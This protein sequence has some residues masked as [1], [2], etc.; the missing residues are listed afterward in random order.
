MAVCAEKKRY[1]SRLAAEAALATA[2]E[3]WRKLPLRAPEPPVRV[4][5]CDQCTCPHCGCHGWHLTHVKKK[6]VS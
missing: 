5:Q 1:S 3:Q 4:Y 6:V 2:K